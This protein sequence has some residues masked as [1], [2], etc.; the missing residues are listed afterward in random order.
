MTKHSKNNTASS[1]F[2]Y[3]EHKKLNYGTK[4]QR[5]GNESM[6]RFDA[7]A[8]CLQRARDPVACHKGHLF[9]KECV[10]TDLV[11]QI[12]DIK[13]QKARLEA[14]K[15]E[16]ED[17]RERARQVA[18]ERVLLEFEKG[19][20][21]LAVPSSTL[22]KTD[23]ESNEP[24]GTKR[25]FSFSSSAVET[26]T[27]EAEEAALRQI[28]REQAEALKAKLPDF[29]LPSLTPTY[30]SSGPPTSLTDIKIHTTCRGGNPPHALARK[31]LIPVKFS[32]DTVRG[33]PSGSQDSTPTTESGTAVLTPREDQRDP[34]CPSCKSALT[35]HKLMYLMKPCGHVVDKTCLDTLVRPA[36]QCILC[37]AKLG[38][39]DIIEITR[40]GT[41]FAG[42]GMAESSRRGVAF[43]G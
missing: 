41:G 30:T 9:C 29:W 36:K 31:N 42:G 33:A 27:Q 12:G 8:L 38:D 4:R 13:R 43:Q 18:R 35:N 19:Q 17:E 25:K 40:E 26:L 34:I 20:L 6:R 14:L 7:C 1:V 2:S 32:F 21:G 16:A 22:T 39:T 15:R 37:D 3:A 10:Y 24:R 11:T 23:T 5:L 28:E